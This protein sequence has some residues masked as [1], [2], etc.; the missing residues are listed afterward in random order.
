MSD[1]LRSGVLG[2][3]YKALII[4]YNELTVHVILNAHYAALLCLLIFL[5]SVGL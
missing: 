5:D 1:A 3:Q 4:F 2:Y